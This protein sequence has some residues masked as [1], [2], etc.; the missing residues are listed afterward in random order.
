MA[1]PL[2]YGESTDWASYRLPGTLDRFIAG[3]AKALGVKKTEA[4]VLVLLDVQAEGP[5]AL[6]SVQHKQEAV[7]ARRQV[8]SLVR[9]INA[10]AEKEGRWRKKYR[11][12]A[13][14]YRTLAAAVRMPSD[15]LRE[16][17]RGRLAA[18]DAEK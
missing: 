16:T 6:R 8:A 15:K 10:V 1:R 13:Y 5:A 12:L 3:R 9:D 2:K 18:L 4:L 17:I 11:D 14:A 7:E